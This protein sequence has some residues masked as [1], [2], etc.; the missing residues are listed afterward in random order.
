MASL[1]HKFD[2]DGT[3]ELTSYNLKSAFTKLGHQ[4]TEQEVEEIMNEHDI[5]HC[6]TLTFD[7]FRA[8]I[9]DHM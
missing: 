5:D 2:S 9:L 6:H 3:N 8:M 7:E 4:M 1:F